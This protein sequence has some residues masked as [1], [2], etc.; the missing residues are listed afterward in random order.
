MRILLNN[1]AGQFPI[2]S[3]P[4]DLGA[5]SAS[6]SEAG[7]FDNDG[8]IDLVITTAHNNETRVLFGDG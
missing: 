4:L 5:G 2:T 8:E 7:D 1:G 3:A 6:P